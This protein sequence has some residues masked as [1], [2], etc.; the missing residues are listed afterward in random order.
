MCPSFFFM[1][2]QIVNFGTPFTLQYLIYN[3][4][5]NGDLPKGQ[6]NVKIGT[7]R[8]AFTSICDGLPFRHSNAAIPKAIISL[9]SISYSFC[10]RL[11]LWFYLSDLNGT[12]FFKHVI[13]AL[14]TFLQAPCSR[15]Q[16]TTTP[17]FSS[18]EVCSFWAPCCISH[19]SCHVLR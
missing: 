11:F 7:P 17:H 1:S 13:Y 15:A 3:L 2:L 8:G 19:S 9:H 14:M 6:T 4:D 18:A 10:S 12:D 5:L 16:E